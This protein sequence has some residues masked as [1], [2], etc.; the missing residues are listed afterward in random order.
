MESVCGD[1]I[2]KIWYDINFDFRFTTS[3]GRS[4]GFISVWDKDIFR[5]LEIIVKA[6]LV[7]L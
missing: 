2:R 7:Q 3:K 5:L 4:G 6:D 1:L